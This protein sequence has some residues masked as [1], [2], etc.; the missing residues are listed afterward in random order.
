MLT[1]NYNHVKSYLRGKYLSKCCLIYCELLYRT[2]YFKIK[3]PNCQ[4]RTH[5]RGIFVYPIYECIILNDNNASNQN[6]SKRKMLDKNEATLGNTDK[7]KT[8]VYELC[9]V[10]KWFNY[11]KVMPSFRSP[12]KK[13]SA[14]TFPHN[15]YAVLCGKI[16]FH[17]INVST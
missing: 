3:F 4:R 13:K 10:I 12:E 15:V 8:D 2:V 1:S 14:Q 16:F 11:E 9:E 6:G 7:T 5:T 17:F